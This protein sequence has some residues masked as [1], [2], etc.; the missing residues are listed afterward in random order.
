MLTFEGVE[1][2]RVSDIIRP[3][4]NFSGIDEGVLRRKAE[5][6]SAV[7]EAIDEYL[8][9]DIPVLPLNGMGYFESFKRWYGQVRPEYLAREQRYYDK[10]LKITGC[11]DGLIQMPFDKT[12]VLLDYKTSVKESPVTWKM[13]AHLYKHLLNVNEVSSGN[14]FLFLRLNRYGELP[15]VHVY[16]ECPAIHQKCVQSIHDFWKK[17][18]NSMDDNC[19]QNP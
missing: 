13:Q 11:I 4:T 19:V 12:P 15:Y 18:N 16:Y 17:Y 1:Y 14:R 7:H 2:A 9:G 3:F 6:G 8:K 5:L 10:E